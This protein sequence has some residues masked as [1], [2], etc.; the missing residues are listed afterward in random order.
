MSSVW[1]SSVWRLR[2]DGRQR[3]PPGG[4]D[5]PPWS[6]AGRHSA[7]TASRGLAGIYPRNGAIARPLFDVGRQQL[8]AWSADNGIT[9]VEDASNQD[10]AN[11]RNLLRHEVLPALQGW[12]GPY[13]PEALARAADV[14]RADEDLLTELTDVLVRR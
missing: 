8:R 4:S 5:M 6:V 9:H 1:T 7:P 13:V 12:L 2:N 11:P 10:L 3:L 14:A